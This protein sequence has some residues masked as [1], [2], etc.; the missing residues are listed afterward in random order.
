MVK[1]F[2]SALAALLFLSGCSP[3]RNNT[4]SWAVYYDTQLP[5]TT[6]K[7]LDLVVFD[8]RHY[9]AFDALKDTTIVLAYISIGEVCDDAPE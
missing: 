8:R 2:G 3:D 7:N 5:A 4:R 9:P 1:R 6:F